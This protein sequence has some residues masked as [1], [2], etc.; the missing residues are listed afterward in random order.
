MDLLT[1][2]SPTVW[3][4]RQAYVAAVAA[5]QSQAASCMRHWQTTRDVDMRTLFLELL[6]SKG[7]HVALARVGWKLP[8]SELDIQHA[9]EEQRAGKSG[10]GGDRG[11]GVLGREAV[12]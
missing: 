2:P 5:H 9:A 8:Y 3:A 1:A 11:S 4:D 7:M 12:A 6:F 10:D